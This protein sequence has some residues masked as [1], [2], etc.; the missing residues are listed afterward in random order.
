MTSIVSSTRK[1]ISL[2]VLILLLSGVGSYTVA[3]GRPKSP[4]VRPDSTALASIFPS[5]V[6]LMAYVVVAS[7]CGFCTETKA[8]KALA[9]LRDS[10]VKANSSR[11]AAVRVIGVSIDD[12]LDAGVKYL[13]SY[14]SDISMAFDQ[15]MIGGSW[16]NDFMSAHAWRDHRATTSIPQVLFFTRHVDARA[17]PKE[18]GIGHDTLVFQFTGRDSL[19]A[20]VNGGGRLPR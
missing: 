15:I 9:T 6:Y 17:Y 20:F 13:Q 7:D 12:D 8:K 16:L 3:L 4:P 10:L 2:G 19:L 11:Y 14:R 18:I 5:G 1:T